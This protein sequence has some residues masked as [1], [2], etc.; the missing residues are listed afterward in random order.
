MIINPEWDIGSSDNKWM[1][2]EAFN[3]YIANVFYAHLVQNNIKIAVILFL[4]GMKSQLNNS[5]TLLCS[6]LQIESQAFCNA[7][8]L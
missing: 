8:M 3:E 1:T 4:N 6:D 5:L 2:T 7:V